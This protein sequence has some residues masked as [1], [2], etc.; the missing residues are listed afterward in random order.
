MRK[1]PN[2]RTARHPIQLRRFAVAA[3][4]FELLKA[5]IAAIPTYCPA[6]LRHLNALAQRANHYAEIVRAV[7]VTHLTDT[8]TAPARLATIARLRDAVL[9]RRD[10]R[11]HAMYPH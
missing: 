5:E 6:N 4:R 8:S 2:M 11:I 1:E 7:A 9:A 3:V 10:A